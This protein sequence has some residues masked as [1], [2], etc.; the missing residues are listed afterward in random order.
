MTKKKTSDDQ[1]VNRQ[2]ASA[3]EAIYEILAYEGA[4]RMVAQML[5][6]SH[7][8]GSFTDN[9]KNLM[10]LIWDGNTPSG[11]DMNPIDWTQIANRII[12]DTEISWEDFSM[13]LSCR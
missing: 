6:R 7:N 5:Q 2:T 1:W 12:D 13:S 4:H 3:A 9:L 10:W 8:I 11:E